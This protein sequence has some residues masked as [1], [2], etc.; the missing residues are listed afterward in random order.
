MPSKDRETSFDGTV[1]KGGETMRLRICLLGIVLSCMIAACTNFK[2]NINLKDFLQTSVVKEIETYQKA[3]AVGIYIDATPSM[4]GFVSEI[5][6][7]RQQINYY[8]MCMDQTS[9]IIANL[10]DTGSLAYYRADTSIW[11]MENLETHPLSEAR[12]PEFYRNSRDL[13]EKY[14]LKNEGEGEGDYKF[15][16]LKGALEHGEA[17]DFSLIITDFYENNGNTSD[18]IN[19]IKNVAKR[20]PKKVF[21]IVGVRSG[22]AGTLYDSGPDAESIEFGIE[23][24]K[25]RSFYVIARGNPQDVESF[26]S[27]L[28]ARMKEANANCEMCVFYEQDVLGIDYHD[29]QECRLYKKGLLWNDGINV[30]IDNSISMPVYSYKKSSNSERRQLFFSYTIPETLI[31]NFSYINKTIGKSETVTLG[32]GFNRELQNIS[33]LVTNKEIAIWSKNHGGFEKIDSGGDGFEIEG[34]YFD[35]DEKR[36][37][38]LLYLKDELIPEAVCRIR[39]KNCLEISESLSYGWCEEW[40]YEVGKEDFEKTER[41]NDY[42]EAFIQTMRKP[43]MCFLDGLIYLSV[44]G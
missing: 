36:L 26:C 20:N 24:E 1:C 9:R 18:L 31:N 17:K 5:V 3:K 11:E 33:G 16:C 34:I 12:S 7:N 13:S 10:F 27:R 8:G 42:F 40:N 38:V 29:N 28:Q 43:N 4:G 44:E 19:T 41:L 25:L 6:K 2:E 15:L 37:Y 22:F 21:G 23:E 14:G 32:T 35:E 30:I 39:W